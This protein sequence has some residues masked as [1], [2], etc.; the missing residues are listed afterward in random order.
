M[1][2]LIGAPFDLC[3][4]TPGS[5]LG[6]SALRFANIAETI[7]VVDPELF[8]GGDIDVCL[9]PRKSD[10]VKFFTPF[11]KTSKKLQA[12]V[13]AS[14]E[15]GKLPIML[16]G[17][18]GLAMASVSAALQHFGPKVAVLWIDAHADMNT[19]DT[20]P[21]GN[22]HGMPVAGLMGDRS[23]GVYESQWNDLLSALGPI[24]LK[25]EHTAWFGLRDVDPGER[26]RVRKLGRSLPITMHDIDRSSVMA[27]MQRFDEWMQRSDATHLWISFD[28]DVL[29]PILAPGTGTAVRGGLT[30]RE[31]HLVAEILHELMAAKDC[32]YKLAGVD[33]VETNPLCD[34]NNETAKVAVEWLASL[35]G[36]TILGV[37]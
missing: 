9:T 20:S 5:R 23:E 11:L 32:P 15:S 12:R 37:R 25:P 22:V 7:R 14:L 16:G 27:Q 36:K 4:H 2:E 34:H 28:V 30:Y 6:P 17:D 21:S 26:D 18:H 1:V 3:G 31:G 33:M 13:K 29:D 24:K 35:F 19:P 10:Q 8:D